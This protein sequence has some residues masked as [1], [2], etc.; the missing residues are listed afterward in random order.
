MGL[1]FG[2]PDRNPESGLLLPWIFPGITGKF[3]GPMF[4]Q[5]ILFFLYFRKKCVYNK[6]LRVK[7]VL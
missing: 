3:Q 2:N 1:F 7:F 5:K 6:F 4:F